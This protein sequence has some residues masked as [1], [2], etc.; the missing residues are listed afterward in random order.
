[1]REIVKSHRLKYSIGSL[2]WINFYGIP[3]FLIL[4]G[5]FVL[6]KDLNAKHNILIAI[7]IIFIGLILYLIQDRKLRFKSF[8]LNSPIDSFIEKTRFILQKDGWE[9]ECDNDNYIQAVNRTSLFS[10]DLLTIKYL[11]HEIRWNLVHHP[12]S[13]NSISSLISLNLK[14]KKTIKKIIASA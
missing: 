13:H 11:K 5:L 4:I 2:G 12:E 7:L 9:I 8:K 3:I 6:I 1:M 14:G 10:L